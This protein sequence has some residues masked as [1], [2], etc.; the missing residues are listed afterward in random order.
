[1]KSQNI[2]LVDVLLL[3]PF[4]VWFGLAA[5]DVHGVARGV[6]I[7]S[8]AGTILYNGANYLRLR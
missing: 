2:R 8:G 7:A 1:V 4:M 5:K 3:G 6:M